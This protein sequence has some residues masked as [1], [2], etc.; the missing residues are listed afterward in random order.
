MDELTTITAF[1]QSGNEAVLN[2]EWLDESTDD[3]DAIEIPNWN[4]EVEDDISDKSTA[5]Q[6]SEPGVWVCNIVTIAN[7][8]E[9]RIKWKIKTI[10]SVF[11]KKIK[12]KVPVAERRHLKKV[13]SAI[14]KYPENW[15]KKL[16]VD[17]RTCGK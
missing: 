6:I 10:A 14:F 5:E 12:T 7:R 13:M 1:D 15:E 8:P 3:P 16:Q 9:Y 4:E 17:I 11:G 2:Y